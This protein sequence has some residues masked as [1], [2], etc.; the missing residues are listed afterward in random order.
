MRPRSIP[1]AADHGA[2]CA[3]GTDTVRRQTLWR[4][5]H[6][7]RVGVTRPGALVAGRSGSATSRQIRLPAIGGRGLWRRL[8]YVLRRRPV[9]RNVQ[10]RHARSGPRGR[11]FA[12][13]PNSVLRARTAES[14]SLT[15][16][17]ALECAKRLS[18]AFDRRRGAGGNFFD[19]G[20]RRAFLLLRCAGRIPGR[21]EKW[22]RELFEQSGAWHLGHKLASIGRLPASALEHATSDTS[23]D[24]RLDPL[25]DNLPKLLP[26][27]GRLVHAREFKRFESGLGTGDQVFERRVGVAHT[28]PPFCLAPE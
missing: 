6:G 11:R 27:V 16:C 7:T 3:I 19:V 10:P 17:E 28:K 24:L 4:Y 1:R 13:V 15:P 14:V 2:G 8:G 23:V 9:T 12:T 18:S 22:D 21:R 5:R 25:F 26:Q 20:G